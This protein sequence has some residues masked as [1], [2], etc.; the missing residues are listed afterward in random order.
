MSKNQ[1][2]TGYS[3]RQWSDSDKPREKLLQLGA[4]NVTDVE[5]LAIALSSGYKNMSAVELARNILASVDNNLSH[6]SELEVADLM[7]FKGVGP[8][9]AIGIKAALELG[10]RSQ[11][12]VRD[13]RPILNSS[14][15]AYEVISRHLGVQKHEECWALFLNRRNELIS[16]DKMSSGGVT[17]T[18]VDTRII[19]K[20]AV[21]KLASGL[22]LCHNHPSGNLRPSQSDRALTKKLSGA[23]EL[24]DMKLLDH[25]IVTANGYYSFADEGDTL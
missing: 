1:D 23:C 3:I 2:N 6:L 7:K 16:K 8:A 25:L 18:V 15:V 19:L 14:R 13:K 10:R 21:E 24:I 22:I 17:G 20:K 4:Q 9:K 5:L 11:L 12:T